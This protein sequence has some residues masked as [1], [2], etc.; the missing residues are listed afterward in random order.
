MQGAA[1]SSIEFVKMSLPVCLGIVEVSANSAATVAPHYSA[2]RA[3][4]I[5][6]SCCNQCLHNSVRVTSQ[7][8][9][10]TPALQQHYS[11]WPATLQFVT[12]FAGARITY[13]RSR[14][15]HFP[16]STAQHYDEMVR[17]CDLLRARAEI[18]RDRRDLGVRLV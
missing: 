7:S 14:V 4:I 10:G 5:L 11:L 16:I 12:K 2:P 3:S 17:V 8:S 15:Q 13:T 9:R 18:E 6:P 1:G